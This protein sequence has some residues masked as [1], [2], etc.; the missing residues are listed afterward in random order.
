MS[1]LDSTINALCATVYND[2]LPKRDGSKFKF[3]AFVD[4]TVITL[5]LFVVAVVASQNDGLLLLGLKIQSWTAGPLVGLFMSKILFKKFFPYKLDI[6]SVVGAYLFGI[7]GVYLNSQV[8]AWNWNLNVYLGCFLSM[9]F[10]K[11]YSSLRP[12]Q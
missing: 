2:I 12:N 4:T 10:L 11:V 3:F 6:P 8:L 9:M 1:T 5:L 7:L